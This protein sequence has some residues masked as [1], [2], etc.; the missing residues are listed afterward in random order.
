MPADNPLVGRPDVICTPH[1]GASTKEA[2][3]EVAYEIAEAVI[4]ALNVRAHGCTGSLRRA[5]ALLAGAALC[6]TV[7]WIVGSVQG[8][9]VRL[10]P[11]RSRANGAK[12]VGMVNSFEERGPTGWGPLQQLTRPAAPLAPPVSQGEL[13]PSCV[14]AP[15][16]AP[17]VL[18]E[19]Q[20]YTQLADGLGRT[21]VQLVEGSGF[22][23][24]FITYHR[25]AGT[26]AFGPRWLCCAVRS[27]RASAR[28]QEHLPACLPAC[29]CNRRPDAP[30]LPC[31]T[32]HGG[33]VRRHLP[34]LLAAPPPAPARPQLPRL[35]LRPPCA[36]CS[37]RGDDLDTRLLR[38]MVVKG[39][40]EQITTSQVGRCAVLCMWCAVL[41]WGCY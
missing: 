36:A 26:V 38:A 13:T 32:P 17:E 30:C 7:G 9:G 41:L 25:W 22:D 15:M 37:P 18:K 14:N 6:C 28:L 20:P 40:L 21:A 11:C 4:S 33:D 10:P 5:A 12:G 39:I 31:H 27:A 29:L 2:Q 3:E 35:P 1:L 34:A 8:A 19:L 24:V 16:M 23:D